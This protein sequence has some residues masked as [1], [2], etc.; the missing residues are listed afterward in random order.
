[1]TPATTRTYAP[2]GL[3]AILA[4]SNWGTHQENCVKREKDAKDRAW[5]FHPSVPLGHVTHE[6]VHYTP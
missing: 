6:N 5:Q 1:M 2:T 4:H 3:A